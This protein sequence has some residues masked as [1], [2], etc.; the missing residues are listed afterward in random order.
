METNMFR[1]VDARREGS[2]MMRHRMQRIA[3]T[4]LLAVF[5][6]GC[7]GLLKV[8]LPTSIPEESLGDPRMAVTLALSAQGDFECALANYVGAAAVYTDELVASTEFA[9]DNAL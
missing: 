2:R 9:A 8:D 4:M 6:A 5:G 7:D 1:L 3:A